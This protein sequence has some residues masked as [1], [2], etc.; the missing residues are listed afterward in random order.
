MTSINK[1]GEIWLVH[2]GTKRRPVVVVSN[3]DYVVAELDYN[4]A[5]I[6][7]KKARHQFDIEIEK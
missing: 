3:N 2:E 5:R 1:R 7:S 4:I 6:T